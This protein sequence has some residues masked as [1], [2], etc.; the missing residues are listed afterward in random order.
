MT[1]LA[2]EARS[3]GKRMTIFGVITIV[4]GFL[5]MVAP[6]IPGMAIAFLIGV[7]VLIAGILR[8]YW[9]FKAG[10]LGTGL[11]KFVLG[12]LTL[13]CGIALVSDPI[14]ASGFLTILLAGYLFFDGIFE[15][16]AGT[17]LKPQSGWGWMIFGGI[18]SILLGV[19]IWRQYP[20]SGPFAIGILLGIKLLFIGMIMVTSG[21]TVQSI[22]AKVNNSQS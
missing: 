6:L 9:A 1:E 12:V 13:V 16:A 5:C 15:I 2:Q 3:G 8:I 22:A 4:L 17:R 14:I 20:L 11:L 21:S 7:L 19:M 10:S 18:I